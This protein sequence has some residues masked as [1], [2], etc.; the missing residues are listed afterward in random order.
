[1]KELYYDARPNKSQDICLMSVCPTA[2][3]KSD[4]TGRIFM[5]FYICMFF[6]LEN[7]SKKF[8]DWLKSE[9]KI[10]GSLH[11]DLC[12]SVTESR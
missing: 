9:K 1:M 12:T 5:K 11:E 8:Q 6:F 3:N 10:T 7:P 2:W 4:L